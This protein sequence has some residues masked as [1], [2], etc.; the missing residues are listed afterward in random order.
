MEKAQ[1][2]L[3]AELDLG[4]TEDFTAKT[5]CKFTGTSNQRHLRALHAL[6]A[7]PLTREQLDRTSGSANGPDLVAELR[8]RGLALPCTRT[9]V[10]D[11]DGF[12]VRRGV[13]SMTENDRRKVRK[14]LS[15]KRRAA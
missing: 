4:D 10:I 13:Y 6:L 11:R 5:P 8:R 3:I 1:F 12:I 15:E 7:R 9:P 2:P 14:F